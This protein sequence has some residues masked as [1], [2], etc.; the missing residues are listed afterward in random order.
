MKWL[1]YSI[2]ENLGSRVFD[3]ALRYN[4]NLFFCY[5]S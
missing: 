3:G 1:Y 4:D 2:V 5:E